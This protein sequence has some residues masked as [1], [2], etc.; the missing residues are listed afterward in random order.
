M[1]RVL[2]MLPTSLD[3]AEADVLIESIGSA[4]R[5]SAGCTAV[6]RSRGALM[7]P[8]ARAGDVGAILEADFAAV[9][10]VMAALQADSFQETKARTEAAG[11][12]LLLYEIQ[13]V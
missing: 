3:E 2:V 11:A 7:G 6:S 1:Y 5:V 13:G 9:E 4:L 10:D 8:S 12:T